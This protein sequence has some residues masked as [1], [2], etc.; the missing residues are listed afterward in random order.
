VGQF[1]HDHQQ[2][3]FP[4]RVGESIEGVLHFVGIFVAERVEVGPARLVLGV[5]A[6][7]DGRV[8][9][10]P[11]V[12]RATS[13]DGRQPRPFAP[14]G[15]EQASALPSRPVGLLDNVL[16]LVAIAYHTVGQPVQGWTVIGHEAVEFSL[17]QRQ[18]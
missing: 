4:Q 13:Q 6:Q 5:S 10:S 1:A 12:G 16:G 2:E 18:A 9:A 8:S 3:R 11:A 7:A 17:R 15:L 14:T